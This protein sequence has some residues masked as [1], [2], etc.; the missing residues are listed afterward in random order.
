MISHL[1]ITVLA[2]NYA[3]E[4][5]LLAEHGLSMLIEADGYRILFDT[6]QGR[7]AKHNI[8]TL[9]LRLAG[10]DAVVLSH[11]HYDH[12]GGL[13]E[14]LREYSP[15]AVYLHP[16]AVKPKFAKRA[17]GPHQSVGIPTESRKALD[18]F[19]GRLVWTRTVTEVIPGLWCTGEIPRV[20]GNAQATSGF[21]RDAD[22]HVPDSLPDDQALIAE[23]TAGLAVI[24]GCAHSGLVNILD[25]A[26]TLR[27]CEEAHAL[28]GGFHLVHSSPDQLDATAAAIGRRN[29]R[30][31]APCHCT[32][33]RAH[34]HLRTR[35]GTLVRDA[36]AGTQIHLGDAEK[37]Q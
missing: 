25:Q 22:A 12:T 15:A 27:G 34:A 21:F 29:C 31:L 14:V 3:A 19:R 23:T 30:V 10:L 7:V 32:G 26:C 1:R 2:D 36:G 8:D 33:L 17:S 6:G 13:P 4:T 5:N 18:A 35:F 11:G 20:P 28:V 16:A 37:L 24:A 9:G